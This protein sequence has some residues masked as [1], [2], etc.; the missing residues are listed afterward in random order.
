[1]R[2]ERER[3]EKRRRERKNDR[4]REREGEREG[5]RERERALKLEA[6]ISYDLISKVTSHHF[7]VFVRCKLVS[8]EH[9]NHGE[10]I[11]QGCQYQDAGVPGRHLKGY[12]LHCPRK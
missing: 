1:M 3:E 9:N 10:E 6:T 12:L 11:T 5:E 2:G 4:Q 7:S 8:S